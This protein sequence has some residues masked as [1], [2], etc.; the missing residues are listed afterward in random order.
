LL[1]VT[2]RW[3]NVGRVPVSITIATAQNY[4]YGLD[5]LGRLFRVRDQDMRELL[6]WLEM[7]FERKKTP[8]QTR[9]MGARRYGEEA[10]FIL[11]LHFAPVTMPEGPWDLE[12]IARAHG[13]KAEAIEFVFEADEVDPGEDWEIAYQYL[14][15]PMRSIR[16]MSEALGVSPATVA[17]VVQSSR[18]RPNFR[19]PL[20]SRLFQRT[21][22]SGLCLAQ[23]WERTQKLRDLE[24]ATEEWVNLPDAA[25]LL[26][27][28]YTG[29]L[30]RL[31]RRPGL[32]GEIRSLRFGSAP[33]RGVRR[34][35]VE[36]LRRSIP[37][38]PKDGW[39]T[40]GQISDRT[41]WSDDKI[42]ANTDGL[43]CRQYQSPVSLLETADHYREADV[44]RR[45]GRKPETPPAGGWLTVRQI[46]DD[47]GLDY[48]WIMAN[49]DHSIMEERQDAAGNVRDHWPPEEED[50]L[51]AVR[52]ANPPLIGRPP[53]NDKNKSSA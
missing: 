17:R 32:L 18:Y 5:T 29:L 11:E 25:E 40:V 48:W 6:D 34:A 26:G 24:D 43:E 42:L 52:I 38:A 45:L 36:E 46:R 15:L 50:R 28:S 13:V 9:G 31:S 53:Q 12:T 1:T 39:F 44:L 41:G 21:Q 51:I 8:G 19:G 16:E 47:T 27:M 3:P 20:Q 14:T 37:A 23:V 33:A 49:I 7:P 30:K 2:R 10:R 22:L 4:P 35:R